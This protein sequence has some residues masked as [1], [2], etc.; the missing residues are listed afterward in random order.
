VRRHFIYRRKLTI[1]LVPF[2]CEEI[3]N[4]LDITYSTGTFSVKGMRDDAKEVLRKRY[5][6]IYRRSRFKDIDFLIFPEMLMTEDIIRSIQEETEK[7]GGPKFI[8]NGSIWENY[9]NRSIL[10]DHKGN[11]LFAYF[12]PL[13]TK[14][15]RFLRT[16][17]Q[18]NLIYQANSAVPTVCTN[19]TIFVPWIFYAQKEL[20]F[21]IRFLCATSYIQLSMYLSLA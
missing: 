8:I 13:T 19:D 7:E 5:I 16:D 12:E 18:R 4:I 9:T 6:D 15:A 21:R 1:G 17:F 10:T 11:E 2:T 14:V 20:G 3:D